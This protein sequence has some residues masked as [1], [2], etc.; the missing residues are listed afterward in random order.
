VLTIEGALDDLEPGTTYWVH[1]PGQASNG[2]TDEAGNSLPEI[3][4]E[5]ENNWIFTTLSDS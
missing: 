2:I 1:I 3:D 4:A 5:G